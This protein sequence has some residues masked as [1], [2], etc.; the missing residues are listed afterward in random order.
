MRS[1]A[2]LLFQCWVKSRKLLNNYHIQSLDELKSSENK[3]NSE[4]DEFSC[5]IMHRNNRDVPWNPPEIR[6]EGLSNVRR[7]GPAKFEGLGFV[8]KQYDCKWKGNIEVL[9]TKSKIVLRLYEDNDRGSSI[10]NPRF[11]LRG[12][13]KKVE[14]D[15]AMIYKYPSL[16][17]AESRK[18]TQKNA[19]MLVI[20]RS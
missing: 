9:G 12:T 19:R 10:L 4:I 1:N 20:L 7:E 3:C 13:L 11:S 16:E 14:P 15:I 2:V 5:S 18:K 8:P 6:K 17:I